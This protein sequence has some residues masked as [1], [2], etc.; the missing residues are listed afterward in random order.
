VDHPWED[1]ITARPE[2]TDHA[3]KLRREQ[4]IPVADSESLI[5]LCN[6]NIAKSDVEA[7]ASLKVDRLNMSR[8]TKR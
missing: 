8:D 7:G 6:R 5:T 2:I 4:V 3:L 1:D